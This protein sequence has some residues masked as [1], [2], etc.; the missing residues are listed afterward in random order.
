MILDQK[1]E[2]KYCIMRHSAQAED[3]LV[4]SALYLP[5]STVAFN[6]AMIHTYFT[7]P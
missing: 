4:L 7:Q 2:E 1:G 5:Q 6:S 3:R